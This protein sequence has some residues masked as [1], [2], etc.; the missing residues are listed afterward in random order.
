MTAILNEPQQRAVEHGDGPLLILAGAGTGKTRVITH[1]VAHLIQAR[2][3][4]PGRIMAVTFTRKAAR[5]MVTRLAALLGNGVHAREIR[6]GTFHALSGSLLSEA[7][8]G[9]ATG[10]LIREA[11]QVDLLKEILAGENLADPAW[12]PLEVLRRI[13]LAKGRLLAPDAAALDPDPLFATVYGAYDRIL[14]ERN[15]LDFDDLIGSLLERWG[16]DRPTLARHQ[17][18]FSHILVD[19]FQDVN[20]AQYEWLKRLAPHRN[21]MVVGDSDQSI[22]A[23]RGSQADMFQRF[24]EDF[25]DTR[26]VKL[27]Q[28]Y[29]SSQNILAAATAVI[30]KNC[31]P[32][33]CKLWS[34]HDPGPRPRLACLANETREAAFVVG[35]IE[36]LLGGSS[37]YQLYRGRGSEDGEAGR[38][39][40]A[41]IAVLYRTHAQGRPLVDALAR[42]GIPFQVV[43]ERAPFATEGAEA[44]LAYLRFAADSSR[45]EDLQAIFN[46]PPRGLG[47]AAEQWLAEQVDKGIGPWEIL[48]RG[49]K[50]IA[51][52]VSHQAGVD[53][54]R[55]IIT[56]LQSLL[57]T[58]SLP[59]VLEA[60]LGETGLRQHVEA[61][62][63][64][65]GLESFRWLLILAGSYEKRPALAALPA[66]IE[67]LAQW[68]AG[69]FFDPRADAVALMTL[70]AAKG[71]EFPVVFI[72]GADGDLLPLIR[73]DEGRESVE[74]ERRLFYVAMTR[75]RDVLVL[76]TARRRFLF[77]EVREA[78]SSPFLSEI[79]AELLVDVSPSTPDRRKKGP[80]ER[81]LTLF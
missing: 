79:P 64:K 27:E 63:S 1:R 52:P 26:V 35:E 28:N 46:T 53:R 47:Q 24:Q 20:Q 56:T 22:Y 61:S 57:A 29:R 68:R 40:F 15:L 58:R 13:S 39:G 11:G 9:R 65:S 43:G 21:L 33:T 42:S 34:E 10:E 48:W 60:T 80:K 74:E 36:R 3:V 51:L 45:I 81:Q 17:R 7:R 69:D 72:S 19:E 54:L 67:D 12:H 49:S 4:H 55:R 77:G 31:N 70:H 16:N 44:L 78:S 76:T 25:P 6:I 41:D 2:Q 71:L 38:Y 23:F 62:G 32:L 30:A 18:L 14:K 73:K 37:H 75:A 59:E 50:N 66:F 8:G 5:E